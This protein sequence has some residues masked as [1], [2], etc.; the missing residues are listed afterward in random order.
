MKSYAYTT[1]RKPKG[2]VHSSSS[3]SE[4]TLTGRNTGCQTTG[5]AQPPTLLEILFGFVANTRTSKVLPL[6]PVPTPSDELLQL[7]K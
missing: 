3:S 6:P 5:T 7:N 2:L 4:K 1:G